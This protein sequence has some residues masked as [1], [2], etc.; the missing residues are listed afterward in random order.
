[1]L[2]I[3]QSTYLPIPVS[4]VMLLILLSTIALLFGK[5]K[6]ALL[7]NCGFAL[8]WGY[9]SNMIHFTADSSLRFDS[10]TILYL[11]FGFCIILLAIIGFMTQKD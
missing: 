8:F 4:Q 1:M 7:I 9:I 3:L 10:F 5:V 11:G 2:E 6:L